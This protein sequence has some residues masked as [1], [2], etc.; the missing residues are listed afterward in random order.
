[1]EKA[2]K[3]RAKSSHNTDPVGVLVNPAGMLAWALS[4]RDCSAWSQ[5]TVS[6]HSD[7]LI[8]TCDFQGKGFLVGGVDS[9]GLSA[10]HARK[11]ILQGILRG[12]CSMSPTGDPLA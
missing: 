12:H 2:G 7:I 9:C 5:M 4:T 1:M 8:S 10:D 3:D 6:S 11:S